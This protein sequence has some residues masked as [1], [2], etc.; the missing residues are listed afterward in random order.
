MDSV[1][2]STSEVLRE[3]SMNTSFSPRDKQK[4]ILSLVLGV[5]VVY[6]LITNWIPN[7]VFYWRRYNERQNVL[8]HVQTEGVKKVSE[9]LERMEATALETQVAAKVDDKPQAPN[10]VLKRRVLDVV[11]IEAT[12]NSQVDTSNI[13]SN[14]SN[15]EIEVPKVVLKR[16]VNTVNSKESDG[17]QVASTSSTSENVIQELPNQLENKKNDVVKSIRKTLPVLSP[18][19]PPPVIKK[20]EEQIALEKSRKLKQQQD[21]AYQKSVEEDL[22][23]QNELQVVYFIYLNK[24]VLILCDRQNRQRKMQR[25]LVLI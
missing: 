22:R 7:I 5:T 21:L 15:N 13:N 19:A 11:K 23:K 1:S 14:N 18:Y 6:I 25:K 24:Y 20:T 17:S 2:S 4:L 10:F 9:S 12:E 16:R 8:K 3:S